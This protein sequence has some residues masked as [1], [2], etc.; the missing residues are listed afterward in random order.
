MCHPVRLS[1]LTSVIKSSHQTVLIIACILPCSIVWKPVRAHRLLMCCPPPAVLQTA[2]ANSKSS[3]CGCCSHKPLLI[4][5]LTRREKTCNNFHAG[6]QMHMTCAV[7]LQWRVLEKQVLVIFSAAWSE[8]QYPCPF[9][10]SVK[11]IN[12]LQDCVH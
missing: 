8:T 12:L 7:N 4:L 11:A 5:G 1:L 3:S 9:V 2:L 10:A 6:L